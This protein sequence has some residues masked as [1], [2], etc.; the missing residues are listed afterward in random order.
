MDVSK[1]KS[2]FTQGSNKIQRRAIELK[3]I[4]KYAVSKRIIV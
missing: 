2:T 4:V 1:A 3:L